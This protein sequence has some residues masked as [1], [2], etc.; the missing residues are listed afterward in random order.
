MI[1]EDLR[2]KKVLVTGSSSGI[3]AATAVE[4][5][6]QGCFVGVHYFQ[7]KQGGQKTLEQVKNCSDGILLKADVRD[8]QQV[9]DMVEQFADPFPALL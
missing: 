3:G 7:T 2:D 8:R 6:K 5:A 1:Y 9:V 4:F